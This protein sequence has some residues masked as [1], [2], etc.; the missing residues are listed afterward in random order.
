MKTKSILLSLGVFTALTTSAC[1]R[2]LPQTTIVAPTQ[3]VAPVAQDAAVV[4]DNFN[5]LREIDFDAHSAEENEALDLRKKAQRDAAFSYGARSALARR[6]WEIQQEL[7]P[8]IK[9][10][11]QIWRFEALV[12]PQPRNLFLI[13]PVVVET[14]NAIAINQTGKLAVTSE[15]S[16]DIIKHE[17]ILSVAPT[18]RDYLEREWGNRVA[19]PPTALHPKDAKEKS[20]WDKH[21]AAGWLSGIEQAEEIF[22]ADLDL[23]KRDFHGI[24]LYR[25][26][27]AKNMISAPYTD[28]NNK[29]VIGG[30]DHLLI[31]ERSLRITGGSSLNP[32]TSS[33]IAL[34][35]DQQ[36][37]APP[38]SGH[39]S[40]SLLPGE[41]QSQ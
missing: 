15:R 34:P 20:W 2:P 5:T 4:P 12:I 38:T 21:L 25:T 7:K 9:H 8:R 27:L 26:L 30:G 40:G 33:W 22:Q 13:P 35:E 1:T 19:P 6:T 23:L 29:G 11:D 37:T 18:W 31:G 32:D 36:K 10:L 24:V 17:Q 3:Q 14:R 16:L 39:S 28:Q 41:P